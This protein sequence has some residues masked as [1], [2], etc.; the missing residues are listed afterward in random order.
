MEKRKIEGIVWGIISA[1]F[2]GLI[3]LFTL[4][5]LQNG[6][7]VATT[8]VYRFAIAII[9][10]FPI[11]VVTGH[12][13]RITFTDF[14]KLALVSSFYLGAVIAFFHSF[15]YLPS[16]IAATIQFLYPVMVMLIM[17][18]FFHEK[19]NWLVAFSV[20]IGFM[21]ILLL[22]TASTPAESLDTNKDITW[23]VALALLAGLGNSLYMVSLQVAKL[24]NLDGAVITFYVMVFGT[25]FSLLNALVSS[26]LQWLDFS[27]NFILAFLLALVTA[28]I[29]NLALVWSIQKTGST[30]AAILGVMEPVTAVIIGITVFKDP[31]TYGLACGFFLIIISVLLAIFAPQNQQKEG[32]KN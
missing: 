25:I 30:L 31:F 23:G 28:V 8:L 9:I 1:A 26:S 20:A 7:S 12:S 15:R 18:F 13:L 22:S 27:E 21:G 19:F 6:I 29:S 17:V 32:H 11:L 14:C 24:P 16:S 4:P 5:M 3:P 2:Y 10:M